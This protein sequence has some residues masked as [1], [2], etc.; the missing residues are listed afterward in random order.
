MEP[1]EQVIFREVQRFRQ[2]WLWVILCPAVLTM[3]G[4]FGYGLVKQLILGEPW[5][6]NPMPDTMLIVVATLAMLLVGLVAWTMY[7]ATLI[8]EVRA[9]GLHIKFFPFHL[10]FQTIDLSGV[11]DCKAVTY[12]PIK[13]Y[14]G[15]GIRLRW[16]G[17]AYN[18]SGNRGVKISYQSG[19]HLLIGSQRA[20]E[21]A[22]AIA[23][24]RDIG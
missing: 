10:S 5:G 6:N 16:K 4:L 21:L 13:E 20:E 3:V 22:N 12:R 23:V 15:W 18:V 9:S 19:K 2:P 1:G 7:A 24:I 8:T 17:K 11:T 14:G